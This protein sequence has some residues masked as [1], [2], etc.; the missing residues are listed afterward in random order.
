MVRMKFTCTLLSDI[1]LN[2]NAAIWQAIRSGCTV[3]STVLK[4]DLGILQ[5]LE[6][7]RFRAGRTDS[8]LIDGIS[9]AI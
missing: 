7:I 1:I 6:T 9:I 3:E 4:C 2:Q 8:R 5:Q